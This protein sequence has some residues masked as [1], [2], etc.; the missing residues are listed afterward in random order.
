MSAHQ[1]VVWILTRET[2]GE[3]LL[4]PA[5]RIRLVATEFVAKG[6]RVKILAAAGS[7]DQ[8]WSGVEFGVLESGFTKRISTADKV[9]VGELV[10]SRAMFELLASD[11]PF[12]WDVYGLSLPETLS[13]AG[14]WTR[15]RSRADSRRKDLRYV[16]M[17]RA[18]DK[19]WISH[20]HQGTFLAAL[21]ARTGRTA[22][23]SDAFALP[24]KFIEAPMG[25]RGEPFPAGLANPYPDQG[26]DGPVFLWGGGVWEW[27]DTETV[28]RAFQILS[29][30]NSPGSL[31][32]LSGRNEANAD[33][34][35][36]LAR[37]VASAREKG[38][39]GKNVFFNAKRVGPDQLGAWLE[40]SAGGVMGNLPT[41]E[42]RMAWRTRYLD[43]MWAG[44]PLVVSGSDPL[45]EK[46]EREGAAI[47]VPFSDPHALADAIG[48]LAADPE[49]RKGMSA[50][51]G[52][53]GQNLSSERT[54]AR[55]LD[56][57]ANGWC[58]GRSPGTI[59]KIRYLL[60]R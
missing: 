29:E 47:V 22:D 46:M 50:A 51:S 32:F 34:D 45:A 8:G 4:G 7:V 54:L 17:S 55:A 13:F 26:V 44:R 2:F 1:G 35:A 18:A 49:L 15:A 58:R 6:W 16:M 30:R 38:L 37:V 28:V 53:F 21:M 42:S 24:A 12:H 31:F 19:I 56:A 40:H 60:G 43:L 48:R 9:V 3:L 25:C 11:I 5:L 52:R 39:I 41:L 14:T 57:S 23:L 20:A 59:E 33:Y 36:P 10:P 27:F